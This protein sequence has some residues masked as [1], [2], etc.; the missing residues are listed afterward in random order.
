MYS[1]VLGIS[2]SDT[3]QFSSPRGEG[4]ALPS[5]VH[6]RPARIQDPSELGPGHYREKLAIWSKVRKRECGGG[7]V[8]GGEGSIPAAGA[9]YPGEERDRLTVCWV[10]DQLATLHNRRFTL[11]CLRQRHR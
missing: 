10:R 8:R 11:F 1:S 4:A 7:G 3:N 5:V 2:S 6:S 9:A